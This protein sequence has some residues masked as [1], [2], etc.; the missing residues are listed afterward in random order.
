MIRIKAQERKPLY[1]APVLFL[2]VSL[3]A[4]GHDAEDWRA[5]DGIAVDLQDATGWTPSTVEHVAGA[6]LP[7]KYDLLTRVIMRRIIAA[8]DPEADL[9][10]DKEYTDWDALGSKLDTWLAP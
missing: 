3:G 4:G 1:T 6:Y 10:K 2:S 5:L 8:K 9:G 7:S